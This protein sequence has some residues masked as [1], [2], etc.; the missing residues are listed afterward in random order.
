MKPTPRYELTVKTDECALI[1]ERFARRA[2]YPFA[3]LAY[4]WGLSANAVT[5]VAGLCW[6]ASV[7]LVVAAGWFLGRGQPAAGWTLWLVSGSLWNAGYVLDLAD[8]S[9][10]RMTDT[11][12]PSGFYLDYVFHLLFKPAFLA[13]LGIALY[14]AHGGGLALLLLAVLAIP[15]NWSASAAAAEHVLCEETGKRRHRPDSATDDAARQRLWLG[16]TDSHAAAAEKTRGLLR[17]LRVVAQEV[18]S[19]YGQFSFFSFLA[20]LDLAAAFIPGVRWLLP[21]TTVAFGLLAAFLALRIP[22]RV[23]R[24]FRRVRDGLDP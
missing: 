11:A 21:C 24:D 16:A 17:P 13:S 7:P 4:R 3:C 1:T 23:A 5:L 14:L 10:A 20:V 2:A 9:L 12:R 19:Y 6:M 22:F 15:A 18:L 8:G